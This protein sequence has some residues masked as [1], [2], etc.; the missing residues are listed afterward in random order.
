MEHLKKL[1]FYIIASAIA[2]IMLIPF[3]WS[4]LTSIK[5]NAEIFSMPIQWLPST[6]TFEHYIDAFESVPFG[7]YMWNS[8]YLATVGVFLNLLFGSMSGY[9]FAKLDFAGK[10]FL[11]SLLIGA[12]M[13]P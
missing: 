2:V 10:K 1:I 9:A 4:L 11:F 8:A 13:I 3:I 7:R 5:P 12:M 6:I